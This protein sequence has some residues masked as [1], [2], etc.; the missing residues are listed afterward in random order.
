[1]IEKFAEL[2]EQELFDKVANHLLTQNKK[3][4][5]SAENACAYRS[6]DGLKCAAGCLIEDN[7]YT[8]GLEGKTWA[9]LLVRRCVKDDHS[10]LIMRLQ[11][12]HDHKRPCEW[13]DKLKNLAEEY[14]LK[15]N[16]TI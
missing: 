11:K 3:S 1:M 9:G 16:E 14:N 15:F 4:Y 8:D 13:K 5:N 10:S 7:E 12:I 6:P 2:T